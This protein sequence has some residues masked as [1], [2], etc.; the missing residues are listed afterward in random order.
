MILDYFTGN[1]ILKEVKEHLD[2]VISG[3]SPCGDAG[4]ISSYCAIRSLIEHLEKI[5]SR[6]ETP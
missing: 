1:A 6:K 2:A 5:E 3:T 4:G